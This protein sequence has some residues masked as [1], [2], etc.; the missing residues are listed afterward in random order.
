MTERQLL[1]RCRRLV[2]CDTARISR[3]G[4]RLFLIIGFDRHTKDDKRSQ[5]YRNGEPYDYPYVEEHVIA[6]GATEEELLVSVR[7]YRRLQG[8]T[9]EEYLLEQGGG[10]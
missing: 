10:R 1:A 3:P 9:M 8:M 6:S 4:G 2:P 7:E 5:C